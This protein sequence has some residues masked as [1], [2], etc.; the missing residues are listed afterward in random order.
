M[1]KDF[2]KKTYLRFGLY[3]KCEIDFIIVNVCLNNEINLIIINM[4]IHFPS[5]YV[6][7]LRYV[8]KVVLG[9]LSLSYLPTK[10]SKDPTPNSRAKKSLKKADLP[11]N[12]VSRIA[13]ASA[14]T[15]AED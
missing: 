13:A 11:L 3:K 7:T 5:P 9:A 12:L 8:S 15:P 2:L 4:Y 10:Q 6:S 1:P 14:V